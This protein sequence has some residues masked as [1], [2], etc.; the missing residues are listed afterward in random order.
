[1][2]SLLPT[3]SPPSGPGCGTR[4]FPCGLRST[5]PPTRVRRPPAIATAGRPCR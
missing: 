3:S 1:V 4:C 5:C 2:H